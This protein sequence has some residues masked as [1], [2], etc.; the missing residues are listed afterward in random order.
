MVAH[1][2][3]TISSG[4][5]CHARLAASSAYVSFPPTTGHEQDQPEIP[6]AAW[7]LCLAVGK[8]LQF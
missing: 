4:K 5:H 6:K 1:D 8:F 3:S 2:R 7:G